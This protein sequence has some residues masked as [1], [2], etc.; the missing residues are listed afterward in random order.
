MIRMPSS[1]SKCVFS[2]RLDIVSLSPL[3]ATVA[4]S[5]PYLEV[6]GL[7]GAPHTTVQVFPPSPPLT[8]PVA[9]VFCMLSVNKGTG[10]FCLFQI[11]KTQAIQGPGD[12][13]VFF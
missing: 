10:Q 5:Y 3:K 13:S 11:H 12:F 4:L 2:H 8:L 9:T 7:S 6:T 1:C